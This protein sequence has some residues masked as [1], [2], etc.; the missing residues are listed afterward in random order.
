MNGSSP[1]LNASP[2]WSGVENAS[3]SCASH[4]LMA[5]SLMGV[6]SPPTE[7]GPVLVA[8]NVRRNPARRNTSMSFWHL[9]EGVVPHFLCPPPKWRRAHV[10]QAGGYQQH[11]A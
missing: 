8:A 3:S 5:V 2:L 6:V 10:S 9:A 11:Q 4:S 7:C 1:A